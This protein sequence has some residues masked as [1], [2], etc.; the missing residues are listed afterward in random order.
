VAACAGWLRWA[1]PPPARP[2]FHDLTRDE[3]LTVKIK[4]F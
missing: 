4:L 3:A 1:D 2:N